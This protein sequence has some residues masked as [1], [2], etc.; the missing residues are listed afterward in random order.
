MK[1]A[2]PAGFSVQTGKSKCN[3]SK[4]SRRPEKAERE[5]HSTLAASHLMV[6]KLPNDLLIFSLSIFTK[7]A[8]VSVMGALC[9]AG[10]AHI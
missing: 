5:L 4:I 10:W 8:P 7:P 1:V 3:N 2:V 6:K 9:L